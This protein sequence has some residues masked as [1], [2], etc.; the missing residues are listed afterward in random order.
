MINRICAFGQ[1][2]ALGF[3][4]SFLVAFGG[5][6]G[7]QSSLPSGSGITYWRTLSGAAGDAQDTLVARFNE[8]HPD[9]K[10]T[11]EFQ[12]SYSDL[13]TKLLTAA[14]A[15]RGPQVTQLGTFEIRQF[16]KS[17][18]LVDL[19]PLMNGP[20]G[21]DTSGWSGTLI[22][23]GEID[24]GVYWLPF[25]VAVPVLYYNQDAFTDAGLSGPPETW[26][27]FFSYARKLT[28]RGDKDAVQM[29]GLALWNI[30]WP[31]LSMFWSEGGE[32][33]NRDYTNITL[34]DPVAVRL[35]TELQSLVREGA[36]TLPDKASG[37][38][39]AAFL[40]GRAAMI[41]DSQD[42]FSE[43]FTQATGF[44]PALANYPAGA[45][46]KVYAPGGGGLAILA[47]TT[48]K[49]RETAWA[50]IRHM[51]SPESIAYYARESGYVAFTEESRR[52]AGDLLQ[53][54]R[55]ATIHEALPFLRADYSVNMS[56][57]V[58]NAFDEAF[59]KI[60]VQNADVQAT[61]DA[62][63]TRAEAAVKEELT[64]H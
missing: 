48:P 1:D 40:S 55:H 24:G 16:A 13:A 6:G 47:N 14:A 49:Q 38:H 25:N 18:V 39:R 62:A 2:V 33:T 63:D 52:A 64:A 56:P 58:R 37:G 53:D 22:A 61:L 60:L 9:T 28:R 4:F 21:L 23:A 3:C 44:T 27:D 20:N 42:A 46:G 31:L 59:Q 12:G 51:I 11:S 43:V 15:R 41:L 54:P 19:K 30:T 5:C 35:L 50:F 7:P 8:Q 26:A 36:A 17:G 32:L 10:V 34:N 45:K 29:S 57:A